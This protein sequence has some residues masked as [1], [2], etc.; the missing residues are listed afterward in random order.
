MWCPSI[1][2]FQTSS[3]LTTQCFAQQMRWK[4]SRS[5]L[6]L[7]HVCSSP[8][9]FTCSP[10]PFLHSNAFFGQR[11]NRSGVSKPDK[12]LR[13]TSP[14]PL[15]RDA[16][17]MWRSHGR[18][19]IWTEQRLTE[20][21]KGPSAPRI[22]KLAREER[23]KRPDVPHCVGC[24]SNT[25]VLREDHS[26]RGDLYRIKETVLLILAIQHNNDKL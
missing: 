8:A 21:E 17:T 19:L 1:S 14:V 2:E 3:S 10:S 18:W 11:S 15:S 5:R 4:G 20:Q 23:Q 6:W 25:S 12:S 9:F 7:S 22:P 16:K 26:L 13:P 24:G